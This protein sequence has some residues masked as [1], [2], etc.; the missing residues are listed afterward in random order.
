MKRNIILAGMAL[1]MLCP[2]DSN[3]QGLLK[4]LKQKAEDAVTDK[5]GK[6]I[7]KGSATKQNVITSVET[8]DETVSDDYAKGRVMTNVFEPNISED[9]QSP[10]TFNNIADVLAATPAMPTAEQLLTLEGRTAY[11]NDKVKN[12]ELALNAW[13]N[14]RSMAVAQRSLKMGTTVQTM[15][16]RQNS[17]NRQSAELMAEIMPSPAEMLEAIKKAGLNPETASETE[18]MNAIVP[19]LAKK[20]GMSESECKKILNMG[21]KNPAEVEAY[22]SKNHPALWAKLS[23]AK[24]VDSPEAQKEGEDLQRYTEILMEVADSVSSGVQMTHPDKE[25]MQQQFATEWDNSKACQQVNQMEKELDAKLRKWME[26]NNKG[27]NDEMPDF[28]VEGRKNQNKVIDSWNKTQAEQWIKCAADMLPELKARAERLQQLD[29]ELESLRAGGEESFP[30]CQA[31]NA[32][33]GALF[34]IE[35][36]MLLCKFPLD[37]PLV[38]HVPEFVVM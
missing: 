35:Q 17:A 4:K 23:K 8:S 2:I 26:A 5:V 36:Y 34:F 3:A 14:K 11:Y 10:I 6:K 31:R 24:P 12:A 20:W 9:E 30:Y 38:E 7:I 37:M 32:I 18:I 33:D 21:Q 15:Q 19:S 16:T 22:I 28:W 25:A 1:L 29:A 13:M 27:Y